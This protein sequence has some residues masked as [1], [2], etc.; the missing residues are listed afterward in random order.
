M[1]SEDSVSGAGKAGDELLK[2]P[3]TY[4]YSQKLHKTAQRKIPRL[5]GKIIKKY[6]ASESGL[7]SR[8]DE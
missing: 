3:S 4:T 5:R 7:T 8:S 2:L 6:C 1:L